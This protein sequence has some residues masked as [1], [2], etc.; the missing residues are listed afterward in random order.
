MHQY[1]RFIIQQVMS[2]GFCLAAIRVLAIQELAGFYKPYTQRNKQ[3]VVGYPVMKPS[4]ARWLLQT[5][6]AETQTTGGCYFNKLYTQ[7]Y[8]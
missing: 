7:R 6:Y 5:L 1:S 8:K 4:G 3:L 2:S